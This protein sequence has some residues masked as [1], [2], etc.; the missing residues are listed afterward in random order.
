LNSNSARKKIASL[1]QPFL[2]EG[3]PIQ[4]DLKTLRGMVRCPDDAPPG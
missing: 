3:A 2:D 4:Q 1:R